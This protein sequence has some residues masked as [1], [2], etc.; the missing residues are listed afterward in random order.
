MKTLIFNSDKVSRYLY[1]D[2]MPV[3]IG[4]TN[5]IVGTGKDMYIICDANSSTVTLITDVSKPDEWEN[6]KYIYDGEWKNIN[7]EAEVQSVTDNTTGLPDH[8]SNALNKDYSQV[9][10]AV[11]KKANF[12]KGPV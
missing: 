12:N 3:N 9:M 6:G 7:K 10:K 11:D 2:S 4:P 1:E 8:L 5:T